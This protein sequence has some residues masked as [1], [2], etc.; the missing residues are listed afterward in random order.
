MAVEEAECGFPD[1]VMFSKN[2]VDEYTTTWLEVSCRLTVASTARPHFDSPS[3]IRSGRRRG[4][5]AVKERIYLTEIL[6]FQG[7]LFTLNFGFTLVGILANCLGLYFF[8]KKQRKDLTTRMFIALCSIDLATCLT[9]GPFQI[10]V[11]VQAI[12][13]YDFS[14]QHF[15]VFSVMSAI[16]GIEVR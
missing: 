8:I 11:N 1:S 4:R 16:A 7:L 6:N 15:V 14:T 10:L 12:N 5:Q 9:V 3:V 13:Y 2:L